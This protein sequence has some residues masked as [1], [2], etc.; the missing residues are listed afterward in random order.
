MGRAFNQ[1]MDIV[2]LPGGLQILTFGYDFNISKDNMD[3]PGNL[4][5]L[6]FDW[7]FNQSMDNV[8]LPSGLQS[9]TFATQFSQSIDRVALPLG[10]AVRHEC[11]AFMFE[12]SFVHAFHAF[13]IFVCVMTA[14]VE[15]CLARESTASATRIRK[16]ASKRN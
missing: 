4:Q 5:G 7:E 14:N 15:P 11:M 1:S 6:T 12:N 13:C 2:S 10:C 3:L 16:A 9:L 8:A